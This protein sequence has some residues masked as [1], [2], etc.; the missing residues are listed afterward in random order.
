MQKLVTI[1]FNAWDGLAFGKAPKKIV[2][3]EI[4]DH[5]QD[6]LTDGWRVVSMSPVG[7]SGGDG[8][9]SG[10]LAVLLEKTPLTAEV[11]EDEPRFQ[12]TP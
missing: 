11:I 4:E 7:T 1:A 9:T 10:W 2:H 8:R 6:L 5:L 3:G 12:A